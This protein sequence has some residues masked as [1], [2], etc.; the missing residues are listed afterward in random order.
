MHS[1]EAWETPT[2]GLQG[3]HSVA[4]MVDVPCYLLHVLLYELLLS[5][6]T[7]KGY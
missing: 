5:L 2:W 3:A 7:L 4:E 6:K 1:G